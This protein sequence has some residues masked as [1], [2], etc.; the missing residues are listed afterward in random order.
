MSFLKRLRYVPAL[1]GA[2]ATLAAVTTQL[3]GD[4]RARSA[5]PAAGPVGPAARPG[6]GATVEDL[7]ATKF[8]KLPVLTYQPRDGEML[9]AWQVQPTV[10]APAPRPATCW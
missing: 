10:A 1:L 5:P 8:S 9:F 7:A 6:A 4:V 3:I 2:I